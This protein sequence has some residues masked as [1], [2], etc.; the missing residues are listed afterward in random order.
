MKKTGNNR[1][2]YK[3]IV[4]PKKIKEVNKKD[5]L[6]Y[7][8]A[9][10]TLLDNVDAVENTFLYVREV[11]SYG[12][13]FMREIAKVESKFLTTLAKDGT[14]IDEAIKQWT[15]IAQVSENLTRELLEVDNSRIEELDI[16]M[17]KLVA[18]YKIEGDE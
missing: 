1:K 18:E 15:N 7:L 9:M 5:V 4:I 13:K 2:L 12:N 10:Q 6:V 16:K 8:A 14:E 3:P 17:Q 11:K